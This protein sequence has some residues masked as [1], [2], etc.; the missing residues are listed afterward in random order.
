MTEVERQYLEQME[1]LFAHP[2]W[3]TFLDDVVGWREAV[4]SQW[5]AVKPEGLLYLQGRA[6][7][8]DQIINHESLIAS[9]KHQATETE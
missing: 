9:L 5:T 8:L 3:K 1:S 7:S 2:G 6:A 4:A